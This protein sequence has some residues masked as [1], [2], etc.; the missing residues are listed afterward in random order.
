MNNLQKPLVDITTVN[1]V[2]SLYHEGPRDPF[3]RVLAGQLADMYVYADIIRYPLPVRD[4]RASELPTL[5]EACIGHD[6]SLFS[7]DAFSTAERVVLEN[8]YLLA[9]F[10]Q[11]VTWAR[12][13]H[14]TLATILQL[15]S[16][17]WLR[18]GH[19]SRVQRT[20]V[21]DIEQLRDREELP[22][23]E[24]LLKSVYEKSRF[25]R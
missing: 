23:L 11:F 22:A 14:P 6:S 12:A 5:L 19:I 24:K 25:G 20:V 17:P 16:Q 13:N 10:K 15:H 18:K 7:P 8:K 2:E 3:A 1:A 21:F 9:V 4:D